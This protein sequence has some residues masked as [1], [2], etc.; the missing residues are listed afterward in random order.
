M[1]NIKTLIG[2]F[3][4]SCIL[5]MSCGDE[6]LYDFP[7]DNQNKV[8]IKSTDKTVN[9][10][11]MAKLDVLNTPVGTFSNNVH[12]PVSSTMKA[13]GDLLISLS[14]VPSLVDSYNAEH[15]TSYALFPAEAVS[16]QDAELKIS[17]M[18]TDSK[19]VEVGID[20]EAVKNVSPGSYLMPLQIGKVEGNAVIST[21][22]NTTYVVVQVTE[23]TDNIWNAAP[24][25]KGSLLTEDRSSWT[26]TANNSSF[27]GAVGNLFDNNESNYVQY[28]VSTMD[29]DTFFIVDMQ[30]E[31]DQISGV[32]QRFYSSYYMLTVVDI[33]TSMDNQNWEHQGTYEG[34]DGTAS[35]CFYNPV[36]ARYLKIVPRE[37][38][39]Y[40]V[41]FREFNIYV[42]E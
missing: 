9:N 1:K 12:I 40:G 26:V 6:M 19:G 34:K 18:T 37:R 5:F 2:L 25:D 11:D 21:D 28:A 32:Y 17:S 33:Y 8:Y 39:S 41:Y 4:L 36:S 16:F 31:Y 24:A 29:D 15:E 10:Y 35:I 20:L 3:S 27:R 13:D 42:K 23:D 22:R 14:I 30:K 7:G 38:T